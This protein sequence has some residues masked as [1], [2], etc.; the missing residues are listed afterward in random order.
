MTFA[1]S[2][3]RSAADEIAPLGEMPPKRP[4]P[5]NRNNRDL[6]AAILLWVRRRAG[7]FRAAD[8]EALWGIFDLSVKSL[9]D[10]VQYVGVSL[11]TF[12]HASFQ[13]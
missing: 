2:T 10:R 4:S 9:A 8:D 7:T 3:L 6:H 13:P 11:Q 1:F 5:V 12:Q